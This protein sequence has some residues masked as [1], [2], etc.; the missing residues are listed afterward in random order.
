MLNANMV[1][2]KYVALNTFYNFI[3]TT[4]LVEIV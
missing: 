4:F 2:T 1:Y 3:V